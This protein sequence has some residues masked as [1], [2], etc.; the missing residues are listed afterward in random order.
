MSVRLVDADFFVPNG[1]ISADVGGQ[2]VDAFGGV[3]VDDL[4]AIFAE[5]VDAAVEIAGFADDYGGDAELAD[6]A[7]AIPARRQRGDHNFVAIGALAAGPAEGV[8]F[9]AGCGAV[10]P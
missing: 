9:S 2:E 7:A 8:V 5:P 10:L 1:G 3:E 4:D 6:E